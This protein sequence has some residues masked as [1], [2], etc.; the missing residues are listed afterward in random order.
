MDAV[1]TIHPSVV[2]MKSDLKSGCKNYPEG[3]EVL[4]GMLIIWQNLVS[5]L[6][7]K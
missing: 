6:N 3:K 4:Y 7:Y 2:L 5:V 1:I